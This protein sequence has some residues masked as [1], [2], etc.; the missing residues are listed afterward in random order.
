M[1]RA[2]PRASA[3]AV[4]ITFRPLSDCPG[5]P[6]PLPPPCL[7]AWGHCRDRG[8]GFFQPCPPRRLGEPAARP[9]RPPGSQST[10]SYPVLRPGCCAPR[11]RCARKIQP[12]R[13]RKASFTI[14]SPFRRASGTI[15]SLP[16]PPLPTLPPACP[17]AQSNGDG[18][19]SRFAQ[20][21]PAPVA[22]RPPSPRSALLPTMDQ[23]VLRRQNTAK[24]SLE[25]W[26]SLMCFF[27]CVHVFATRR[28]PSSSGYMLYG[29]PR[30][31]GG[32]LGDLVRSMGP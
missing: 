24:P 27:L 13:W 30:L 8:R 4:G 2:R 12:V 22:P 29:L 32:W 15:I 25:V 20:R 28:T 14:L 19:L 6:A 26:P 10:R 17:A 5:T 23:P 1:R 31:G 3:A 16:R 11:G 18:T 21:S 7:R 9:P